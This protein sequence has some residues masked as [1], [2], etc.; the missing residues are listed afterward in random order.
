M[1]LKRKLAALGAS[2]ALAL[3]LLGVVAGPVLGLT[4]P[5]APMGTIY[6][7][8][9]IRLILYE[10]PDYNVGEPM[11]NNRGALCIA[12]GSATFSIPNLKDVLYA[13]NTEIS[14][15][16]QSATSWHT[17]NDCASSFKFVSDCHH[18]LTMYVNANYDLL[19]YTSTGSWSVPSMGANNNTVSSL[20]VQYYTACQSAAGV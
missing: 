8:G 6:G 16:G 19:S 1:K 13:D 5:A 12:S 20:R 7:S 18:A 4:C 2:L 11:P 17:W 9:T 10:M 15:N 3:S 14:C